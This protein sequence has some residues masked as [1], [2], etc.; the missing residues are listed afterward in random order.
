MNGNPAF[1][2]WRPSGPDG[3]FEPWAVHALE[4]S[5]GKVVRMTA[6]LGPRLFDLFGLPRHPTPER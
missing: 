2:Q 1:A 3:G 4:M 5:G 6:F